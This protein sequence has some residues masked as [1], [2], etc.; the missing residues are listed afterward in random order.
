[1]ALKKYMVSFT[2]VRVMEDENS[3]G[4][5]LFMHIC[6]RLVIMTYSCVICDK[7]FYL[8]ITEKP[9]FHKVVQ[10]NLSQYGFY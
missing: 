7:L 2:P 8:D 9:H 6:V 3:R 1:M 4:I 10:F 5:F